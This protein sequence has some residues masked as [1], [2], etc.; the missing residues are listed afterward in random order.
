[1]NE[2]EILAFGKILILSSSLLFQIITNLD[3]HMLNAHTFASHSD[4]EKF[5]LR[6]NLL[7]SHSLVVV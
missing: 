4:G 1:M 6:W 3:G 7:L 5:K 2:K